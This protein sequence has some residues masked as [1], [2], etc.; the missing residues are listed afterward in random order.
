MFQRGLAGEASNDA[1]ERAF[2]HVLR[3]E[4]GYSNDPN[5]P[6]GETK[7]GISKTYHPE[8]DIRSLDLSDAK[9]IYLNKYWLPIQC[10][11]I[12]EMHFGLALMIFDCAVNPG[13]GA[14]IRIL[15]RALAIKDDGV[16]G[17]NT[18][19]AIKVCIPEKVICDM[20]VYRI[21]YYMIRCKN[22]PDKNRYL[23]GWLRR[24]VFTC[25]EASR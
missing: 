21:F 19:A 6:G 11:K 5:D 17:M 13:M 15:Q 22:D 1:F 20:T 10:N 18:D 16:L 23:K 7:F 12:A 24:A 2:C 9:T 8:V 4:G 3:C 14:A 25:Q